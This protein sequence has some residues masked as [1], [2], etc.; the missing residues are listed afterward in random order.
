MTCN[1]ERKI[2]F[3]TNDKQ[4]NYEGFRNTK[5]YEVIGRHFC[6]DLSKLKNEV[7]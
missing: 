6:G 1:Y 3:F 2:Y 7:E 5:D 4:L